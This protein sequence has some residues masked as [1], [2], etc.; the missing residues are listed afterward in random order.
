[1]RFQN[2]FQQL[3]PPSRSWRLRVAGFALTKALIV[4]AALAAFAGFAWYKLPSAPRPDA[5]QP[6]EEHASHAG[7]PTA[8]SN[9]VV[10]SVDR[11]E[12]NVTIS[13]GPL[14]NLGMPSMTM[15]FEVPD[16]ALLEKIKAGDKVKFHAHANGGA[17]T[18]TNIEITN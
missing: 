7:D 15:G 12:R 3:L 10:V 8:F 17:L 11:V 13:H 1:M 14:L 9:G 4:A 5:G 6:S 2:R 16:A 18:A